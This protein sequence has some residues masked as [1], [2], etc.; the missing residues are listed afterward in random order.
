MFH[1]FL[2]HVIRMYSNSFP[3]TIAESLTIKVERDPVLDFQPSTDYRMSRRVCP[4]F[5][6]LLSLS[7]SVPATIADSLTIKLER[8]PVLDFRPSTDY[9]MT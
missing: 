6:L 5:L 1:L 8:D 9:R 7:N 3:A 4:I 2:S